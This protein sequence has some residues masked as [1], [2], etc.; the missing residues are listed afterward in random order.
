MRQ[1]MYRKNI[2]VLIQSKLQKYLHKILIFILNMFNEFTV[3]LFLFFIITL[4][5]ILYRILA[6]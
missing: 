6:Q 5:L 4:I 2:K 3:I 1:T